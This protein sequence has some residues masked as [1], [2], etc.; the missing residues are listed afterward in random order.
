MNNCNNTCTTCTHTCSETCPICHMKG[1]VVPKETVEALSKDKHNLLP[2]EPC[3]ICVN[4]KC[5][6]AYYQKNNPSFLQTSDI[7]VPIWYKSTYDEYIVCYCHKITL[8]QIVEVVKN[9]EKEDLTKQDVFEILGYK[10]N[11][12]C[13]HHNPLGSDCDKLFNN[14]IVYAYKQ[15]H[16]E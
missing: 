1:K 3:F 4:H 13:I 12:D 15:K 11:G 9:S 5:K 16:Q 8:K 14:A 6:V 7:L 10:E 2:E